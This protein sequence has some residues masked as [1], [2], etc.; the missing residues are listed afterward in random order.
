MGR[1]ETMVGDG[2]VGFSEQAGRREQSM[3]ASACG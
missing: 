1:G 3:A 2:T